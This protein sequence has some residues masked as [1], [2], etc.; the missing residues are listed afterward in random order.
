M[1]FEMMHLKG[2]SGKIRSA[3]ELVPFGRSWFWSSIAILY[4]LTGT[5]TSIEQIIYLG[6]LQ[7]W[8]IEILLPVGW[9]N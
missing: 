9:R 3:L 1:R 4:V 5:G 6:R 2:P 8:K 7:A